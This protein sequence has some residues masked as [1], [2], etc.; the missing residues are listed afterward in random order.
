MKHLI[1]IFI[2]SS[3]S[4]AAVAEVEIWKCYTSDTDRFLGYYK[5][6]TNDS[7]HVWKRK[8]GAWHPEVHKDIKLHHQPSQQ[9][10]SGTSKDGW[11]YV[12]DLLL[13]EIYFYEAHSDTSGDYNSIYSCRIVKDIESTL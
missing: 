11:I 7:P 13:K 6:D 5:I 8:K 12:I 4:F 2:L 10:L 3:L 9:N 1:T